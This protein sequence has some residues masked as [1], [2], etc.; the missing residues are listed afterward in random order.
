MVHHLLNA[1]VRVCVDKPLA[2][3]LSEAESLVELA[4]RRRLTLMVG[5]NRRFAPLDREL[6]AHLNDA[7][8]LRMDK[9]RSDSVGKNCALPCWMIICMLSIPR[10]GWREIKRGW[11][12]GSSAN[13]FSRE[14]LYAEH[15]FSAGQLQITT[16][17]HRRAGSQREWVQAGT[18][19]G[20]YEGV[21]Y[22][23][24]A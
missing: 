16:S 8:S 12:A 1:G 11:T 21:R 20:L 22:A 6:K 2:D 14:M 10:C 15:H 4:A 3:K 7:A 24:V 23:R 18:D 17:M 9:H 5:F 19:G 13:H